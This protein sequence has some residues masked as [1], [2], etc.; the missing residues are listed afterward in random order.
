MPE[1]GGG[2]EEEVNM[3][4]AFCVYQNLI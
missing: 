2:G 3:A 4:V 1:G